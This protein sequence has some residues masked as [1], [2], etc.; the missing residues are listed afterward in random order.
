MACCEAA[1]DVEDKIPS[2]ME[3]KED[4]EALAARRSYLIQVLIGVLLIVLTMLAL[5]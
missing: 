3:P 2:A 5:S 1:E 4:D